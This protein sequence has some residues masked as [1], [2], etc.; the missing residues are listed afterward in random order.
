MV[1]WLRQKAGSFY[2]PLVPS[3]ARFALDSASGA[4]GCA[5]RATA[6]RFDSPLVP[7]F[8]G[9][10]LDSA[11]GAPVTAE[12]KNELPLRVPNSL[13]S[14]TRNPNPTET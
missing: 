11:S 13:C 14:F 1:F 9:F 4:K 6:S 2:S 8:A 10:A 3:F 12:V 7:R 5:S